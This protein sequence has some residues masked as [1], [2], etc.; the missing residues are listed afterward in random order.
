M[1]IFK[2]IVRLFCLL[3]IITMASFGAVL[4]PPTREL[5]RDKE[6]RIEL[7]EKKDDEAED[8]STTAKE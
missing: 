4:T 1:K 8:D 7:V 6:I 3:L 5:Y 2:K